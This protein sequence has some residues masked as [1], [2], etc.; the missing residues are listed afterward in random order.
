MKKGFSIVEIIVSVAV[1]GI[2]SL[3]TITTLIQTL[4]TNR[5][6]DEYAQGSYLAA[7]GIE[8][9]RSVKE[10]NW[11]NL[12][13][14]T[15]GISSSSGYWQLSGTN[16]VLGKFTRTVAVSA[17]QRNAGT[18]VASGGTVDA[19]TMK[20]DSTVSW[21]FTPL[22]TNTITQSTYL[23]YYE[24]AIASSWTN[25]S[26]ESTADTSGNGNGVKVYSVG[27]YIFGITRLA[28][29][30][31]HVIDITNPAVP[32]VVGSLTLTGTP[33]N[34]FVL[35]NYAYV[36]TDS[37]SA[38]LHIVNISTPASPS[39]TST[40][41][42]S[43]T[44][45]VTN[46]VYV[47]GTTAYVVKSAGGGNE[48]FV[49]NV[50][51]PAAPATQGSVNYAQALNDV[52]VS[53]N[54]AYVAT[55]NTSGELLVFNVTTPTAPTLTTTL[56]L[57]ASGSSTT[58]LAI[59]GFGSYLFMGRTNGPFDVIS[60]ATPT[61]PSAIGRYATAFTI[62][63]IDVNQTNNLVFITSADTTKDVQVLSIA[64]P[65]TPTLVGSYDSTS[66]LSG[67]AYNSSLNRVIGA[68]SS[69]VKE[70]IIVKP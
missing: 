3:A 49:I 21:N 34:I 9:A 22:R 23:T 26:L 51:N 67:I 50:A 16:N 19:N 25:P 14:G 36:T 20:I 43:G 39:L 8:A 48:F 64:S 30:N 46:S 15:Y 63:D 47:V 54:Y 41:N 68:M 33:T 45:T 38:E 44:N 62:N 6:S 29:P 10:Q 59:D 52:Y 13:A 12:L 11:T 60:I 7:E 1:L 35:G 37:G 17:V 55:S 42:I 58:A 66:L 31:F 70:F 40:L 57:T 61:A 24:K 27:N 28:T 69:T 5:L 4:S 32:T 56:N 65:T 53:G 2:I 18:I